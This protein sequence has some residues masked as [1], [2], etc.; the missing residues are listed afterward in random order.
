MK[1]QFLG[2]T[3]T[4]T[5]SRFLLKEDKTSILV[6]CGLFHGR[7][8]WRQRNWEPFPVDP[9]SI[10]AAF[11]THAH[12]D[13][14][15]Y[16]PRLYQEGF[17]GPVYCTA[18]TAALL[19]ILLRDSAHLQEEEA[20]YANKKGYS[21][22]RPAL[23]LYTTQD[24]ECVLQQVRN[25]EFGAPRAF[26]P[27]TATFSSAG[28][29]LGS[30]FISIAAHGRKILFS[31]DVGRYDAEVT[32]PPSDMPE[33][34]VL[35]LEST[36]GNRSHDHEG[37]EQTLARIINTTYHRCGVVLAP[38]F[39]VGRCQTLLYYIR[40]LEES[41]A[42]PRRPVYIDSPMAVDATEIYVEHAR[43]PNIRIPLSTDPEH[44]AIK[45]SEAHFVR[46][47]EESLRLNSLE[48]SCIIISA[49]GMATGGRVLHHL[50]RLLPSPKHT[51]LFVG[52][53]AEGTRG[54]A[55]VDGTKMIKIHG[56]YVDVN[57]RIESVDHFSAHADANDLITWVCTAPRPPQTIYL[58]H[59]EPDAQEVLASRLK[60]DVFANVVIPDYRE[61]FDV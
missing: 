44:C 16:L 17:R 28:H 30:A 33:T 18:G 34:D 32:N 57:A 43:D 47:R 40:K 46:T 11:L 23:P 49:N 6:D 3:R 59:G 53:Q 19:D 5:G 56:Q 9:R 13:H 20:A 55:L 48:G 27:F 12:I 31:G 1:I 10:D 21:R 36:Y 37:T 2:A 8:E 51:V 42:I 39:S 22:H 24:A 29:I 15:G 41:G 26:G 58:V 52:Y 4:V 14:S 60:A 35:L 50:R 54:R 7:K 45:C 61:E 38:A 25:V